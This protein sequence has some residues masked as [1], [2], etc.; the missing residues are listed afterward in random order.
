MEASNKHVTV[1]SLSK[2][3]WTLY[4]RHARTFIGYSAW[5][6]VPM[7]L[8]VLLSLASAEHQL[9]IA[10]VVSSSLGLVIGTWVTIVIITIVPQLQAKKRIRPRAISK[11]AWN[12][13]F[14][15]LILSIVVNLIT[16]I[17]LVL[18]IIP[19]LIS[20]ARLSYSQILVVR[21]G[22]DPMEA[23]RE[24]LKRTKGKTRELVGRAIG[25]AACIGLPYTLLVGFIAFGFATIRGQD[26]LTF[27]SL[28]EP[29]LLEIITF[30]FLD[31]LF[32][33]IFLIYWVLM[34]DDLKS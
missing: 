23:V 24:S 11:Q 32:L 19:G 30:Q 33:P 8:S 16:G 4:L 2:D 21:E 14:P 22:L 1:A 5:L 9:D 13:F 27:L 34:F 31:I 17:G 26:V 25:G 6:L 20:L 28:A 3:S 10:Q 12:L 18:L 15:Y 7:A 29:T